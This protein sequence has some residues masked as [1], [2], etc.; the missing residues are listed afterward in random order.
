MMDIKSEL[1]QL[2][3]RKLFEA[4]IYGDKSPEAIKKLTQICRE[5]ALELKVEGPD[6]EN[7]KKFQEQITGEEK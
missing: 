3:E 7:W 2:I 1:Q 4:K 6:A 5:A